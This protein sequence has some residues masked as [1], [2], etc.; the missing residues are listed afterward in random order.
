MANK[1]LITGGSG[2]IGAWIARRL[3]QRGASVRIFDLKTNRDP[4]RAVIGDIVDDMEWVAGDVS[5]AQA[6]QDAASGCDL[7]VH[8]AAILTPA[9]QANPILGAQ[10]TLMGT[11]NVFEAAR[12]EGIG[13]VIYMSSAGVFGPDD[14]LHPHPTTLYG[15]WKLAGEGCARAYFEDHGIASAGFRPLIV[16][17]P[18]RETGLT[19]GPTLACRAAA[20]GEPYTIPFTGDSDYVF[21]DDV[22][23]AFDEAAASELTGAAVYNIVGEFSTMD[24]L[25]AS[26]RESAPGA[27]LSASGPRVPTT[28]HIDEGELREMF[29]AVPRTRVRDGIR[30][31]VEFYRP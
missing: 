29:P 30:E 10:I 27:Q 17:G 11:L 2:F 13:K 22:A 3:V 16:Y 12:A 19:A 23:A 9:C 26:I 4:A 14:G 20:R 8:L 15:A 1:I 25:I 18:G 5:D 7:L 31:T 28:A 6:V 21:V 24:G